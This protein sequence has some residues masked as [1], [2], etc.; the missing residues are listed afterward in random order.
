[1]LNLVHL[2]DDLNIGEVEAVRAAME[3]KLFV[4]KEDFQLQDA[5]VKPWYPVGDKARRTKLGQL[6][7]CTFR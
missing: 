4:T 2:T 3:K 7:N 6:F 1:M 5:F